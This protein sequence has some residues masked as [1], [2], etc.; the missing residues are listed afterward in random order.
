MAA[1][2]LNLCLGDFEAT[3][4]LSDRR[5]TIRLH[6]LLQFHTFVH[7]EDTLFVALIEC[8]LLALLLHS[9][10]LNV[11]LRQYLLCQFQLLPKLQNK[12]AV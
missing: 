1:V 11:S 9:G 6:Q 3:E 2:L 4:L 7:V 10:D 12:V 8:L 5:P